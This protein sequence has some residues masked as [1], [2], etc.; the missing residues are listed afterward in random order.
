MYP[1]LCS[2]KKLMQYPSG[3]ALVI[4][5]NSKIFLTQINET[6]FEILSICNGTNSINDISKKMSEKY[7][8]S[9]EEAYGNVSEFINYSMKVG[10]VVGL[11]ESTYSEVRLLG[12]S[13]FWLPTAISIELTYQCPL[14][15]KHCYRECS[16]KRTET[17]SLSNIKKI[18]N[19]MEMYGIYSVQLT[20]GEP[21]AHPDFEEII[22]IFVEKDIS[23]TLLTS[24]YYSR[25]ENLEIFKR[26]AKRIGSVQISLDGLESTHNNIRQK[27]NSYERAISLIEY[28]REQGIQVDVSTSIIKQTREEIFELS[29][30]LRSLGVSRHRLSV[31]IETG[32]SI[33]NQV[34]TFDREMIINNWTQEFDRELSTDKFRVMLQE[35]DPAETR[36]EGNCGAGYK[37]IRID[38]FMNIHPCIMID[39]PLMNLSSNTILDYAVKYSNFFDNI[40][41]PNEKNCSGCPLENKCRGCM[42]EA[43][44]NRFETE[45]CSWHDNIGSRLFELNKV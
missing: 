25:K 17:L 20:G 22:N 41:V 40:E 32:R 4:N 19:E 44:I 31:I 36:V 10:T 35:G 6:A 9:F 29:K 11:E 13:E 2:P 30:I 43:I 3:F 16:M 23:I 7:S 28:L 18:A 21:L 45:Y 26:H 5:E 15:C 8:I 37:L 42:A 33:E 38:P 34:S 12:S 1:S 39:L 14:F 27:G 24:G